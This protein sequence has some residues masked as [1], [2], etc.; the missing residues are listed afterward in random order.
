MSCPHYIDYTR[1]CIQYF[2]RVI[3]YFGFDICDSNDYQ[4]C[5]AHIFLK[6]GFICKNKNQCLE[7][8][9]NKN[10]L[11]LKYFITRKT[12]TTLLKSIIEEY[13]SSK[14]KHICCTRYKIIEMGLRYPVG[15]LPNGKKI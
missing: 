2:P 14:E 15:L 12:T 9:I 3:E 5:P 6:S 4:D 10:P 13:C 11:L 1:N 7:N 8:L